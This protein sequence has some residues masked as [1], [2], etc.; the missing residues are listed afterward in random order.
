MAMF[1]GKTSYYRRQRW[2][3][4]TRGRA[5]A[6]QLKRVH[7]ALAITKLLLEVLFVQARTQSGPHY[8]SDLCHA[9][10]H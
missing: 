3:S 5:R 1:P 9:R 6:R 8:L 2:L 7:S 4:G 10:L